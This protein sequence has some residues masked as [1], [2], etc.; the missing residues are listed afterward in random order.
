M[1]CP[2]CERPIEPKPGRVYCS[3]RCRAQ[4]H[5]AARRWG[6]Y[7]LNAGLVTYAALRDFDAGIELQKRVQ[8]RARSPY[9]AQREAE[10]P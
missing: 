6:I 8:K 7:A 3:E 1:T 2:W 10:A 4:T 9:T 5:K